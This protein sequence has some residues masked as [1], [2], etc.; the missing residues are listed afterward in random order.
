MTVSLSLVSIFYPCFKIAFIA[1]AYM[2]AG[3]CSGASWGQVLGLTHKI[4]Q[5]LRTFQT[6][7]V[8]NKVGHMLVCK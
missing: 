2:N 7:V 8:L 1:G 4:R 5:D 6:K 3:S